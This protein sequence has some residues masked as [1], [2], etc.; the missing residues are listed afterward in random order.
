M[1]E[2]T[3]EEE[4]AV[5]QSETQGAEVASFYESLFVDE[6]SPTRAPSS[7]PSPSVSVEE[8]Q[9]CE[10][11][12]VDVPISQM[13]EHTCSLGHQLARNRS[14]A[15]LVPARGY[16]IPRGNPGYQLL[17]KNGWNEERGLGRNEEGTVNPIK[18]RLKNDRLGVGVTPICPERVTHVAV[19]TRHR[20]SLKRRTIPR[21]LDGIDIFTALDALQTTP[22]QRYSI[23]KKHRSLLLKKDRIR[24]RLL[25]DE[26]FRS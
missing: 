18:T 23:T 5:P 2:E 7:A 3:E 4:S 16:L 6:P 12:E 24:S 9:F 26:F 8:N 17:L 15:D 19:K 10:L 25:A 1:G 14:R 11:C 20:D 22:E 21:N 13:V